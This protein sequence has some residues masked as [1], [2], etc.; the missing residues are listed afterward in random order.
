MATGIES[1]AVFVTPRMSRS[2]AHSRKQDY[3][4]LAASKGQAHRV[5]LRYCEDVEKRFSE[6]VWSMSMLRDHIPTNCESLTDAVQHGCKKEARM[7][8]SPLLP[9][10]SFTPQTSS[11]RS[12]CASP[13]C[14]TTSMRLG[15]GS[16]GARTN[17][18][19][20]SISEPIS[21]RIMANPPPSAGAPVLVNDTPLHRVTHIH[22]AT[23]IPLSTPIGPSPP[24][25]SF[26]L[27]PTSSG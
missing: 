5:V 8:M 21:T 1:F 15:S 14:R 2:S 9:L 20:S 17:G 24:H 13:S 4:R 16:G 3:D 25:A 10:P 19:G 12:S 27:F 11:A 23:R 7:L 22:T 26:P 6:I 18:L